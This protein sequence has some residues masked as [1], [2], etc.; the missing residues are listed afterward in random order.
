MCAAWSCPSPSAASTPASTTSCSSTPP[1]ATLVL[2]LLAGMRRGA[3]LLVD[4]WDL[5]KFD[6]VRSA[7]TPERVLTDFAPYNFAVN[8]L[9]IFHAGA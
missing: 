8:S 4:N 7:V 6:V 3:L 9:A 1:R 5:P 2:P